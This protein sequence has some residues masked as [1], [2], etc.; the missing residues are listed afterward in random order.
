[1][2]VSPARQPRSPLAF[3]SEG[4]ATFPTLGTVPHSWGDFSTG[5]RES[6]KHRTISFSSFRRIL[7]L[8]QDHVPSSVVSYS[9]MKWLPSIKDLLAPPKSCMCILEPQYLSGLRRGDVGSL[10]RPVN[11]QK[12]S[13]R[14]ME[15]TWDLFPQH[16]D[17]TRT[18]YLS[19]PLPPPINKPHP[20]VI[21]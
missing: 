15:K 19:A 21:L 8:N 1:M 4:W 2:D 17:L 3:P 18:I 20:G 10:R 11:Q 13:F 5:W 9:L 16:H 14:T 7:P 12:P 6:W